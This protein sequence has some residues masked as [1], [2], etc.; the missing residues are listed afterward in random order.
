QG[1]APFDPGGAL[2]YDGANLG[3]AHG[4]LREGGDVASGGDMTGCVEPVRAHEVRALQAE[5][6]GLRV[7]LRHE[8]LPVAVADVIGQR[9]GGVV[10]ALD[11]RALDEV[12]DPDPLTGTQVHRR[13]S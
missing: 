8:G 7:H 2:A 11:Q 1:A 3:D 4:R 12:A 5:L 10:R 13:L 9:V 6:C